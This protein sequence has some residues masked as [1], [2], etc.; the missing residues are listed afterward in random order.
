MNMGTG[1]A[2]DEV[3]DAIA[4]IEMHRQ[5][6]QKEAGPAAASNEALRKLHELLEHERQALQLHGPGAGDPA[7]IEAV[8]AE[9]EKVKRLAGAGNQG[10]N[11][12]HVH[13]Q[14]QKRNSRPG[15]PHNPPRNKGRRTMGRRGDR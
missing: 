1:R 8:T 12:G 10:A 7:N 2:T 11:R 5:E 4:H 9:I 14:R 6:M 3:I 13:D 15:R